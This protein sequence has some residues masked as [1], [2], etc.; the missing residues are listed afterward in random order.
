MTFSP[1]DRSITVSSSCIQIYDTETGECLQESHL[2]SPY[3]VV[4]ASSSDGKLIAAGSSDG[5]TILLAASADRTSENDQEI[6][7][8]QPTLVPCESRPSLITKAACMS[9]PAL[10]F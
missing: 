1:G 7:R 9:I 4:L 10:Y 2:K 6:R 3:H 8:G 5:R